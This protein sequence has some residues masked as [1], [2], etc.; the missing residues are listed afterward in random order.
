MTLSTRT[1][2]EMGTGSNEKLGLLLLLSLGKPGITKRK[3][4]DVSPL[5]A[6]SS[7]KTGQSNRLDFLLTEISRGVYRRIILLTS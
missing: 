4:P 5:G 6:A 2:A 7:D 3:A 1:E